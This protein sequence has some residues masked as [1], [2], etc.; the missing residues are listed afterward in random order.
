M[1]LKK[2]IQK[3]E[4]GLPDDDKADIHIVRWESE[5]ELMLLEHGDQQWRRLPGESENGFVDRVGGIVSELF[6]GTQ[7][8]WGVTADLLPTGQGA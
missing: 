6:H 2:R 3:L 1:S 4:R 8:L 5:A 7:F